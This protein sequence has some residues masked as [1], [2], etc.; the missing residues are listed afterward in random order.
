MKKIAV[1][2]TSNINSQIILSER[3]KYRI[4]GEEFLCISFYGNFQSFKSIAGN[5]SQL[6]IRRGIKCFLRIIRSA[7]AKAFENSHIL[8][9]IF[10]PFAWTTGY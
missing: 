2:R 5:E 6:A 4:I 1:T 9:S 3:D 10:A 8:P 7:I